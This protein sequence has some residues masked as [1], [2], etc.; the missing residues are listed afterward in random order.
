MQEESAVNSKKFNYAIRPRLSIDDSKQNTETKNSD[1]KKQSDE[2]QKL[3]DILAKKE[4]FNEETLKLNKRDSNKS[5]LHNKELPAIDPQILKA[6]DNHL[7]ASKIALDKSRATAIGHVDETKLLN[8]NGLNEDDVP[9]KP[10]PDIVISPNLPD[11]HNPSL[12]SN[13]KLDTLDVINTSNVAGQRCNHESSS[14]SVIHSS[15]SNAGYSAEASAV[16]G[17]ESSIK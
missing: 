11:N 17:K 16:E 14:P 6:T 2:V 1:D 8:E 12:V 13:P 9:A 10:C 15:L 3:Q 4:K 7:L 5:M